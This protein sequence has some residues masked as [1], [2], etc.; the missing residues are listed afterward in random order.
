MIE[1]GV[2]GGAAVHVS[3]G[4][5]AAASSQYNTLSWPALTFWKPW[6]KNHDKNM[7]LILTHSSRDIDVRMLPEY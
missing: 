6:D 7:I 2:R 5:M 3:P 1:G 4:G